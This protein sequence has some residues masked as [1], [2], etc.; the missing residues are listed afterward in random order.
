MALSPPAGHS[1]GGSGE[2]SPHFPAPAR[3][4]TTERDLPPVVSVASG[5]G[6]SGVIIGERPVECVR[7]VGEIPGQGPS[8]W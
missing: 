6:R 3:T 1:A 8:S 4:E 5:V 2:D 7:R